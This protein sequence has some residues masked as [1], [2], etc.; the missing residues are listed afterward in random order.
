MLVK[1]IRP[2]ESVKFLPSGLFMFS[3]IEMERSEHFAAGPSVI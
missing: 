1:H 2:S 3:N